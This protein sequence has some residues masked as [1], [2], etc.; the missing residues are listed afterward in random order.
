MPAAYHVGLMSGT[1]LDGID[2]V[3]ARFGPQPELI[4]NLWRPYPEDLRQG[5]LA[6]HQPGPDELNRALAL[7]NQLADL[8][9]EATQGL[10]RQAGLSPADVKAIGCHGQTVRHQPFMGH[11]LQ[12]NNPARLAEQTGIP[13]VADFRSRDIAAGGQGSPLVAAFHA[14]M[15]RSPQHHRVIVNIGGIASITDLPTDGP[16]KGFDSGPGTLVM[17]A[18]V[19]RHWGCDYDPGGSLAAQGN[20]LEGLLQVLLVHPYFAQNPPK[21]A[22]REHFTMEWLERELGGR[23]REEDVLATL[24]ALTVRSIANA[25]RA[26]CGGA[27]QIWLCGGGAHN[28]E[29]VRHLAAYLPGLRIG[30]TDEL[31]VPAGWAEAYALAWLAWQ[32]L[33]GRPGNL[34]E[35]TGAT[36]PRVLGAI[37]P[38]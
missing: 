10:I 28:D 17:D 25:I 22:G 8:Y 2:A 34:P 26:H 11:T 7:A 15:F 32:T 4:A 14:A 19:K 30:L 36:G 1:S 23:E 18:W 13:V 31:G 29:L 27:R 24:L 20:V 33:A 21:S 35:V 9:A 5:L 37:Y 3:L 38:A 12:L 16:I 6:L